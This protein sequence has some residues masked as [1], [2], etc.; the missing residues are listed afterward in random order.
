MGA[1]FHRMRARIE[2]K[3]ARSWWKDASDLE[4]GARIKS[5]RTRIERK[6]AR[7]WWKDA[8][9]R[10]MGARIKSMRA[11]ISFDRA[12]STGTKLGVREGRP[13]S[14]DFFAVQVLEFIRFTKIVSGPARKTGAAP[15]LTT[16]DTATERRGAP[17]GK[18]ARRGRPS[19]S[20][21]RDTTMVIK[22]NTKA[23]TVSLAQQLIAGTGKHLTGGTQVT[24]AGEIGR[25]SCRERV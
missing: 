15:E 7:L 18:G 2:R 5:M 16:R 1:P 23:N 4:M 22:A 25:A 9:D 17:A 13:S 19:P 11:R 12:P 10:E 21:R 6:D 24:F 8:S 20:E 3:D 14:R